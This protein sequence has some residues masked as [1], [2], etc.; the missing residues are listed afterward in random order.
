MRKTVLSLLLTMFAVMGIQAQIEKGYYT[1]TNNGKY[2]NVLGRK[3]V[4]FASDNTSLPGT[5]YLIQADQKKSKNIGEGEEND[6]AVTTLRSQGIDLPGYASRGIKYVD[7]IVDVVVQ[8]LRLEG[9]GNLFGETGVDA[10]LD[11]FHESFDYNLYLEPAG[12]DQYRIYGKTPSMQPVVEFYGEHK[13][14]IQAKLP[15][16][17]DKINEVIQKVL[18]K[19]DGRGTGILKPYYIHDVW[20]RMGGASSGLTEPVTGDPAAILQF[21]DDVLTNKDNVWNFAYESVM[22]YWETILNISIRLRMS[23]PTSATISW[24]TAMVL[25]SSARA[26]P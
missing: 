7:E 2:I 19:L 24:P 20:T 26:M 5:I 16:L 23:I 17:E 14:E 8:K 4:G 13:A 3:T 6:Y 10:I 15:M 22:M 18:N 1:I 11:K 25:T 9:G 12:T 21:Y